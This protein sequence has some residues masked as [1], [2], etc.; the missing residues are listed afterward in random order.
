MPRRPGR[1]TNQRA[2]T[3]VD[4]HVGNRLR[5]RRVLLGLSQQQLARRLSLTFQQL[6][7]YENGANRVSASRLYQLARVLDVPIMWFYDGINAPRRNRDKTAELSKLM[8]DSETLRFVQAYYR[9]KDVNARQRLRGM[10]SILAG[11][12]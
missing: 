4:S 1:P 11:Q 3:K 9:I 2:S 7:K 10:A 6:Q 5:Q 8:G 12:K